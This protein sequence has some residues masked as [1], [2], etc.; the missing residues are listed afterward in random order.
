M[1]EPRGS[2][3][4]SRSRVWG[5][6]FPGFAV[7]SGDQILASRILKVRACVRGLRLESFYRTASQSS[8]ENIQ[9]SRMKSEGCACTGSN[10]RF[11]E[12]LVC[13]VSEALPQQA[14]S[15]PRPKTQKALEP[16]CSS[17][18]ARPKAMPNPDEQRKTLNKRAKSSSLRLRG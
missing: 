4:M 14:C 9:L 2:R 3:N 18:V 7:Q 11:E 12:N 17:D 10:T 15:L 6:A 1:L 5:R 8:L 13:C 16:G